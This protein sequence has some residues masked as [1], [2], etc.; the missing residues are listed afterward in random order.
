VIKQT[1]WP[2]TQNVRWKQRHE[3]LFEF[4]SLAWKFTGADINA[5]C[6]GLLGQNVL[7]GIACFLGVTVNSVLLVFSFKYRRGDLTPDIKTSHHKL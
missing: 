1:F 7:L 5:L 2:K 6:G 4:F 3:K